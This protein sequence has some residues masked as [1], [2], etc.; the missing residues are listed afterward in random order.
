MERI[1][2]KNH[3]KVFLSQINLR[4]PTMMVTLPLATMQIIT[5][6]WD[7]PV[8]WPE[9]HNALRDIFNCVSK[10]LC[11]GH[12]PQEW[13]KRDK[14]LMSILLVAAK[15]EMVVTGVPSFKYMDGNYKRHI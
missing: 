5:M 14:Y 10:I 13:V 1:R 15:K 9:K 3:K 12:I 2:L 7:C 6:S 4:N 11:F 8:Q